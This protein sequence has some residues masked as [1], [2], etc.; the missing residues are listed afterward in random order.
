MDLDKLIFSREITTGICPFNCIHGWHLSCYQTQNRHW[1]W[2][3]CA[4][5]HSANFE[6]LNYKRVN[7]SIINQYNLNQILNSQAWKN[8]KIEFTAIMNFGLRAM[9][10]NQN[11]CSITPTEYNFAR[12]SNYVIFISAP[13]FQWTYSNIQPQSHFK[14]PIYWILTLSAK[15]LWSYFSAV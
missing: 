1:V 11:I 5:V 3:L 8:L 4:G 14:L 12:N 9:V 6:W 15:P 2:R 13:K 10:L 7:E